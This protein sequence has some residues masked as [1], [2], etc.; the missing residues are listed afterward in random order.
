MSL[1]TT[2]GTGRIRISHDGKKDEILKYYG[3]R[4]IPTSWNYEIRLIGQSRVLVYDSQ[5]DY[6]FQHER[7]AGFHPFK[8][9]MGDFAGGTLYYRTWPFGDGVN[10]RKLD[11]GKDESYELEQLMSQPRFEDILIEDMPYM[12]NG[13]TSPKPEWI[14]AAAELEWD[15]RNHALRIGDVISAYHP[16]Y[17]EP[18]LRECPDTG[19]ML[20]SGLSGACVFV[21]GPITVAFHANDADSFR[22]FKE[23]GKHVTAI[24]EGNTVGGSTHSICFEGGHIEG[25][26]Q[27]FKTPKSILGVYENHIQTN[28]RIHI[29]AAPDLPDLSTPR[30]GKSK[31]G[32]PPRRN[33]ERDL[34]LK[35][36]WESYRDSKIGN[37]E[38]FCRSKG[39][40]ASKLDAALRKL[41]RKK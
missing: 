5:D 6:N 19:Q 34:I 20:H 15:D 33:P 26:A 23:D 8:L 9:E 7:D 4:C 36:E 24:V 31:R 32:R 21:F 2:Y 30:T 25:N 40:Q 14:K 11:P 27:F 13:E 37:K 10:P 22:K 12:K 35:K 38:D 16:S 18:E 39:I 28:S 1:D 41:R 29:A 3:L 17:F